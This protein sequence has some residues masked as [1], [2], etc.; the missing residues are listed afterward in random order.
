MSD[1]KKAQVDA[2]NCGACRQHTRGVIGEKIKRLQREIESLQTLLD[3]INWDKLTSTQESALW[4]YF[5]S[6]R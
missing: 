3:N 5:I 6:N 2:I 1:N 4:N